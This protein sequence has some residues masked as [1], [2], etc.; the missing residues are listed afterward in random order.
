MSTTTA[1]KVA[2]YMIANIDLPEAPAKYVPPS[3]GNATPE[4]LVDEVAR[5]RKWKAHFEMADKFLGTA[6]K[7]RLDDKKEATGEVYKMTREKVTQVRISPEK[8]RE[9]LSAELL[10]QVEYELEMEQMR[11]SRK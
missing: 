7:A 8:C 1:A 9:V 10:S 11:F 3:L 4:T 5:I 6:L 2:T